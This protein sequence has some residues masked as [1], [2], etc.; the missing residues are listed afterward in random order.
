MRTTKTTTTWT[1]DRCKGP[2]EPRGY[3]YDQMIMS[4]D[5]RSYDYNGN[6]AGGTEKIDLC[7][8]CVNAFRKFIADGLVKTAP[9][10]P[11]NLRYE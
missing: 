2:M 4:I 11:L 8:D 5:H 7:S 1:C 3:N 10:T 9:T 6:G